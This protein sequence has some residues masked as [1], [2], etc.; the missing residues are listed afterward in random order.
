VFR[1]I[2]RA[3]ADGVG[4]VGT[5]SVLHVWIRELGQ[6]WPRKGA[7]GVTL[8]SCHVLV[9]HAGTAVEAA[10]HVVGR[11]RR[12][13][14]MLPIIVLID[15]NVDTARQTAILGHDPLTH[16][17][18][19]EEGDVG[20]SRVLR[21]V[22]CG[23]PLLRLFRILSTLQAASSP[24]LASVL[25]VILAEPRGVRSVVE[26]ARRLNVAESTLRYH[27]KRAF[28]KASLRRLIEW[29]ILL[30]SAALSSAMSRAH[31]S[32]TLGVHERTLDRLSRR[33]TGKAY[34]DAS[35]E[36][37]AAAAFERW[38]IGTF[39]RERPRRSAAG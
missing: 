17:V 30:R 39:D 2:P 21:S 28:P 29:S 15:L 34:S 36:A 5:D 18:W 19:E 3:P 7:T 31:V 1:R 9:L 14:P 23:H 4:G 6:V 35:D 10:A 11:V 16:V 13:R 20:L 12:G 24:F 32:A 25:R 8:E 37:L 38:T 26:L 27:W 22:E 33:L